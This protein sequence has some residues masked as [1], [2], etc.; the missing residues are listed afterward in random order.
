MYFG[1]NSSV[2]IYAD[3]VLIRTNF[4]K[5]TLQFVQSDFHYTHIHKMFV[6]KTVFLNLKQSPV[7]T[8]VICIIVNISNASYIR[9][10]IVNTS[11][12][13]NNRAQ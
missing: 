11:G 8:V 13:A 4:I 12:L 7:Q 2:I 6:C 1:V 9:R 5:F 3:H 10:S